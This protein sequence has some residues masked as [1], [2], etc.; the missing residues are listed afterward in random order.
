MLPIVMTHTS[1]SHDLSSCKRSDIHSKCT[2]TCLHVLISSFASMVS[3]PHRVHE[4]E[5]A[6]N[7]LH[8]LLFPGQLTPP[9][10]FIVFQ[11]SLGDAGMDAS[12]RVPVSLHRHGALA[13]PRAR[14]SHCLAQTSKSLQTPKTLRHLYM[15]HKTLDSKP[16]ET[17]RGHCPPCLVSAVRA[18]VCVEG[19][20]HS[21]QNCR[22]TCPEELGSLCGLFW[23]RRCVPLS[24]GCLSSVAWF[25]VSGVFTRHTE[26]MQG[27]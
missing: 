11:W 10:P 2:N 24:V 12:A 17:L 6:S 13:S 15:P 21:S 7:L 25:L 16:L 1:L 3:E 19:G 5:D 14:Q 27:A 9:S 26:V 22:S 4:H 8:R 18:K 23:C 20:W